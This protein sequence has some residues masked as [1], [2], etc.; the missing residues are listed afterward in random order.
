VLGLATTIGTAEP[1]RR[2][3]RKM[4][5]THCGWGSSFDLVREILR[6]RVRV[7]VRARVRVQVR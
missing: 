3:L 5:S 6:V 1:K 7:R 4:G 2:V